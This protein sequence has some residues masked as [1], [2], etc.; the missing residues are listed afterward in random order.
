MKLKIF[1]IILLSLSSMNL[2][3]QDITNGNTA[4]SSATT[5]TAANSVNGGLQNQQNFITNNPDT[6]HYSGS[7]TQHNVPSVSLGSFGNSFSS[8]YCSGTMQASVGIAGF[9]A[10]AGTQKLD[11]GCQLLRTSDMLMRIS[12]VERANA[13]ASWQFAKQFN[14]KGSQLADIAQKASYAKA[15]KADQLEDAAINNICSISDKILK[16]MVAAGIQCPKR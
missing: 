14:Q 4:A 13:A 3:A 6:I 7:F 16:N 15:E 5:N 1:L 11:E 12:A 9:G 8:D 10:A 2:I